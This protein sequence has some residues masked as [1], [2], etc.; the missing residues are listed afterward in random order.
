MDWLLQEYAPPESLS[1]FMYQ[2]PTQAKRL[3]FDVI[4]KNVD[5]SNFNFGFGIENNQEFMLSDNNDFKLK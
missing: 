2:K 4:P 3:F 1:Q 5:E